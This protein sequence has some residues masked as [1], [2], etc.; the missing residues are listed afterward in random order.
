MILR[1]HHE[2]VRRKRLSNLGRNASDRC[3]RVLYCLFDDNVASDRDRCF[4]ITDG[5][6]D[7]REISL[8]FSHARGAFHF[9]INWMFRYDNCLC[10]DEKQIQKADDRLFLSLNSMCPKFMPI[11]VASYTVTQNLSGTSVHDRCFCCSL[12]PFFPI[13]VA[14]ECFRSLRKI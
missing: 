6:C 3:E 14:F 8:R 9:H 11:K 2:S 13:L 1:Y 4:S 12:P 10:A 7:E 5:S